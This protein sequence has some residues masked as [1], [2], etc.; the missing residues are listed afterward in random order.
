MSLQAEAAPEALSS[1]S[2]PDQPAA[3]PSQLWLGVIAGVVGVGLLIA[4]V[5]WGTVFSPGH[6][7]LEAIEDTARDYLTALAD[8]DA[9]RALSL[10]VTVPA[11]DRWLTAE[12]LAELI[13]AHPVTD[14][15]V[16]ETSYEG[17]GGQAVVD[18]RLGDREVNA[19]LDLTQSDS[20]WLLNQAT[21]Q[22]VIRDLAGRT[23][24]QLSLLGQSVATTEAVDLFPGIYQWGFNHPWVYINNPELVVPQPE[25]VIE[26]EPLNYGLVDEA[27]PTLQQAAQA[28]LDA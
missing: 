2:S 28:T 20:G 9:E 4:V 13:A 5:L 1:P 25:Q 24:G 18:Y 16:A 27:Q 7:D 22:V 11:D 8:G 6:D 15:S 10:A 26:P 23:S 14:I 21:S 19:R 3:S 17:S 12:G